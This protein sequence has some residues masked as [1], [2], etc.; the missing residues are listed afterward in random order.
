M[1]LVHALVLASVV[2]VGGCA[3]RDSDIRLCGAYM[4][5]LSPGSGADAEWVAISSRPTELMTSGAARTHRQLVALGFPTTEVLDYVWYTD[6]TQR[7]GLCTL[8]GSPKCAMGFL[9]FPGNSLNEEP[10]QSTISMTCG[11]M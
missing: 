5:T 4:Q 1:T 6:G 2:A 7:L 11:P 8:A 10:T 3:S 9:V